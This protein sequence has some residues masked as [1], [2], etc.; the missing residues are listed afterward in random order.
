MRVAEHNQVTFKYV[1]NDGWFAS[2]EN[3]KFIKQELQKE[4]VM[5]LKENRKVARTDAQ[6]QLGQ[7]VTVSTLELAAGTTLQIWLEEVDFPLALTKEVFTN[8]DGSVGVRYL[9]GSELTLSCD[10]LPKLYQKRWSIEVYHK[11]L[12]QNA[13]LEKSPTRTPTIQRSHLFASLC[14]YTE[15]Q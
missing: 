10:Q 7:Y 13:S 3:M 1:L 12:K 5:P 6:K 9:V 8:K 2:S 14:A 4:F 11:S 15:L